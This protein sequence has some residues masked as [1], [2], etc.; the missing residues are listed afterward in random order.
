MA[1]RNDSLMA[2][3]IPERQQP[4]AREIKRRAYNSPKDF[5]RWRRSRFSMPAPQEVKWSVLERYGGHAAT[6]VET[7]T[8]R[9]DTTAF[10]ARTAQLVITIEP[11][12]M[13]AETARQRFAYSS[14]VR[15]VEGLSEDVLCAVIGPLSGSISFW[16]DG[17]YSEGVTHKGPRDTPIREE[18]RCVQSTLSQFD[19]VTVLVDDFRGFGPSATVKSDYPD[20]SWLVSWADGV[21]MKWTV[22]HDIF[23]A[24]S[25]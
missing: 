4:R 19:S 21:G 8:F 24:K 18:L 17:H 13:L 12:P 15:V 3:L 23:I 9:G 2:R 10:L 22:E 14:N 25:A 1:T 5:W 20:K 6:W 7:G 16:L 11:D